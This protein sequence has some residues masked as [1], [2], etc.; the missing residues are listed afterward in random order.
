MASEA[1][2][3][4]LLIDRGKLDLVMGRAGGGYA[5]AD[6]DAPLHDSLRGWWRLA[7]FVPKRVHWPPQRRGRRMNLFRRRTLPDA[8]LV[9][10]AAF[11]RRGYEPPPGAIRVGTDPIQWSAAASASRARRC[12]SGCGGT[13]RRARPVCWRGAVV[14]GTLREGRSDPRRRN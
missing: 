7:E 6:P 8:P 5:P 4:G 3:A 13:T 10:E 14:R 1:H 9:H 2:K 12:G 11:L